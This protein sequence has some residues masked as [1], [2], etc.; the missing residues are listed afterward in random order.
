MRCAIDISFSRY[1]V[2]FNTASLLANVMDTVIDKVIHAKLF[3]AMPNDRNAAEAENE[4][5]KG[6]LK[7]VRFLW[8]VDAID[9][10]RS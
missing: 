4:A 3:G 8:F 9:I 1:I 7:Q 6:R 10:S 5:K 2:C